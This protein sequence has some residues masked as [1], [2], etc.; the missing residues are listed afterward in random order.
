[1]S[2][3]LSEPGGRENVD[4]VQHVFVTSRSGIDLCGFAVA[5]AAMTSPIQEVAGLSVEAG[6][7]LRF[8]TSAAEVKRMQH[9]AKIKSDLQKNRLNYNIIRNTY[10]RVYL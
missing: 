2:A 5:G 10:V 8:V 4:V 7:L 9:Q 6:F 1:M 3:A